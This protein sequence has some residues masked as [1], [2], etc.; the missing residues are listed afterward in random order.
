M[1][2]RGPR[3]HTFDAADLHGVIDFSRTNVQRP[4][5]DK[6]LA[7][8]STGSENPAPRHRIRRDRTRIFRDFG[9]GFIV[10]NDRRLVIRNHVGFSTR[11]WTD[12]DIS[13][14]RSSPNVAAVCLGQA[15]LLR[16]HILSRPA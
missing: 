12:R 6:G 14:R 7:R 4:Q 10:Q 9:F 8:C 16:R 13:A 5:I 15:S 1:W 11:D 2:W 3:L